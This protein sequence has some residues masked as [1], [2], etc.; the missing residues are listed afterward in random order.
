MSNENLELLLIDDDIELCE[1]LIE[2]L[3]TE[4]YSVNAVH[5]GES[6]AKAALSGD[7]QLV[8]LDVTLP[9]LN[10]FDVLKKSVRRLT[11][12]Y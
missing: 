10:G 1:L 6:G 5:D 3:A 8:L 9:K 11:F 4:G 7:Y 2:Y 12:R